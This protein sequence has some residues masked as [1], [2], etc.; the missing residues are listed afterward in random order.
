[1]KKLV[2]IHS[3]IFFLLLLIFNGFK[4]FAQEKKTFS[5]VDEVFK[6]AKSKNYIFKNSE[7]NTEL[8]VLKKKTAVGNIFNPKINTSA[9]MIN[10]LSQQKLFL[11][12]EAFGGVPG[13]FKQ[14]EV[15]QKFISTLSVQ[16]QFDILNLASISEVNTSKLNFLLVENQNKIQKQNIY[17]QINVLYFNIISFNGQKEVIKENIAIANQILIIILKKNEEGIARNQEVN[18][19]KVNLILLQ[20]QLQQIESNTKIQ[21]QYLNLLLEN[22]VV[23]NLSEEILKTQNEPEILVIQNMNEIDNATLQ[24]SLAQL[25]YKSLLFQNYPSLSFISSFNWQNSGQNQ[26]F[27]SNTYW[28]SFNF[29]GLKLNWDLPTVQRIYNLKNKK[30]EIQKLELI[31]EHINKESA[32]TNSQMVL[33][34]EKA[35]S[36]SVNSQKIFELKEDTYLKNFNQFTE[37]ILPLDK[38]LISQNDMIISKLNLV[39]ALVNVRFNKNKIIINNTF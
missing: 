25:Q 19:A 39:L 32:T 22:S 5:T 2:N 26:F 16:P 28:Q 12:A 6:Y 21:Y 20:D 36:K 1:M 31:Q 24:T 3:I 34:Y 23:A 7:Y 14:V 4:I 37:G 17:Y 15:G 8:A 18:E 10:N 33:E 29:I 35:I 13:T 38:L 9:Q 30:V 11:P 27:G